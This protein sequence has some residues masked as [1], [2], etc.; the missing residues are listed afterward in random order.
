M[1]F[2]LVLPFH[3]ADRP[4][5]TSILP[6]KSVS[7][8]E[9]SQITLVCKAGGYPSPNITWSYMGKNDTSSLK[10]IVDF[11]SLTF[12][13]ISR[14]KGGIYFCHVNNGIGEGHFEEIHLTV[15]CKLRK[16]EI[17]IHLLTVLTSNCKN[18]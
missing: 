16:S 10:S 4:F 3:F 15:T 8:M 2:I 5:I 18:M 7:V 12:V 17:V 11:E 1:I 6:S 13:N 14:M 9:E